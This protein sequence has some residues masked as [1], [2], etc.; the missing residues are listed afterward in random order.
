MLLFVQSLY[1]GH[2]LT[3]MLVLRVKRHRDDEPAE[4][5]CVFDDK[6]KGNEDNGAS[7]PRI[8]LKRMK[9]M[10]YE[11]ALTSPVESSALRRLASEQTAS[12]TEQ[13]V[14]KTMIPIS[15]KRVFSDTNMVVVDMAQVESQIPSVQASSSRSS[16]ILDPASRLLQRGI[17]V[18]LEKGNFDDLSAAL[19]Q[20]ADADV[21]TPLSGKFGGSTALMAAVAHS[22]IR[23]VKRLLLK[24]VN[25]AALNAEGKMALDLLKETK[26]NREVNI[27]IR[28]LLQSAVSKYYANQQR[29]GSRKVSSNDNYVMDIYCV[30]S[31]SSTAA[32]PVSVFKSAET[33]AATAAAGSSSSDGVSVVRIEGLTVTSEGDVLIYDNEHDSDWS[34]LGD[35]EDPDSND[36]RYEGND[37]PEEEEDEDAYDNDNDEIDAVLTGQMR[38][39]G[40]REA[41]GEGGYDGYGGDEGEDGYGEAYDD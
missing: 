2:F 9:T 3:E 31:S 35:D 19:I 39:M 15:K 33:T 40:I 21:Q 26:R 30:P 36:E 32:A 22:N 12:L 6:T 29:A 18:A 8:V 27:E 14:A 20:G 4:S 37:Y 41:E 16:K 11:S 5:I 7:G 34:D 1:F 25:P 28:L 24:D 17:I 38:K 13:S 23:M 10:D